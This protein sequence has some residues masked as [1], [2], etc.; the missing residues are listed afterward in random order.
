MHHHHSLLFQDSCTNLR[1]RGGTVT[2]Q[3]V[4]PVYIVCTPCIYVADR[5]R[6]LNRMF[7]DLHCDFEDTDFYRRSM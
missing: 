5:N 3:Y 1:K 7:P 4:L 6:D 2:Q